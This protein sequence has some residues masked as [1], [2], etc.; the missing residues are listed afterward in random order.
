M[1]ALS[2]FGY[3]GSIALAGACF[4]GVLLDASKAARAV[5]LTLG[6][7]IEFQ[8]DTTLEFEFEESHGVYRST[9]GVINVNTQEKTPLLQEVK[10]ADNVDSGTVFTRSRYTDD[11]GNPSDFL[12]TPGNTVPEPRARFLFKAN[13]KYNFYLDSE[14]NGRPAG[15]LFSNDASNPGGNKQVL[16]SGELV[17]VCA[18]TTAPASNGVRLKWDDTGSLLVR[19]ELR[20]SDYDDFIVD[21]QN[22]PCEIAGGEIL[23]R[24]GGRFPYEVLGA[25]PLLGLIP[26]LDGDG[27]GPEPPPPNEVP[28]APTGAGSVLALAGFG[29]FYKL[30]GLGKSASRKKF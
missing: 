29:A 3:L 28:E 19:Q 15:T 8:Q 17:G 10:P 18:S 14:Y 27:D 24:G 22:Q 23:E 5:E 11:T 2:R 9:F 21:I 6:D 25:L 12:G 20:D 26:L 1:K 16:I 30:K 4:G 7:E 13:E